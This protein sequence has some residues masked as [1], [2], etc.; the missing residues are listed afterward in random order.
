MRYNR[1]QTVR[2]F[3]IRWS[4]RARFNRKNTRDRIQNFPIFFQI[5]RRDLQCIT[6][7]Y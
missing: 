5:Y 7:K 4:T 3:L 6:V 1:T 2:G